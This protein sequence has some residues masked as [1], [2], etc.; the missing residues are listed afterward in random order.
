MASTVSKEKLKRCRG[1]IVWDFDRVLFDTELFYKEAKKIFKKHGVSAMLLWRAVFKIRKDKGTFSMAHVL[2][3]LRKW[4]VVVPEKKIKREIHH[5]LVITK[6][7]T[8]DTNAI[9]SRLQR[10][11]FLHMV[12]SY[13]AASYLHKRVRVGLGKEFMRHFVKISATRKPKYLFFE[14]L[15]RRYQALPVF[16]VD[17]T[18]NN[19]D[20]VKKNAPSVITIYHGRASSLKKVERIILSYAYKRK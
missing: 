11:G 19:I 8:A 14:K 7:F 6:Y 2:R 4:K 5:H 16:F 3:I 10:Y 1:I 18:K 13:G 15:I 17:D 20:L 9:L 12:L